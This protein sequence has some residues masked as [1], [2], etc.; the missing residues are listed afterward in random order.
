MAT[1]EGWIAFA[2][3]EEAKADKLAK[4]GLLGKATV[5]RQNAKRAREAA[6][7]CKSGKEDD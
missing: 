6:E 3:E 7:R 1:Y 4:L 5:H 2:E